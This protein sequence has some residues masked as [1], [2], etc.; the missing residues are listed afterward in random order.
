[1]IF[2]LHKKGIN[3]DMKAIKK[4]STA[5]LVGIAV[6]SALAFVVAFVCN[7]IPPIAGFLSLDVKDGVIAIATFIYGPLAG[8]A[9]AFIA[10]FIELITFSTT[11]WYGFIMNFASSAV[12]ALTAGLIYKHK[13]TLNGALIGF[14]AAVIA[15]T[16]IMLLLNIFVT[17]L[18]LT[19][20]VGLPREAADSQV[21]ELL[22]KVLLPF[23]FAKSLLNS[24]VAMLLYKPLAH[25][26]KRTGLALSTGGEKGISFNRSSILILIVGAVALAISVAIFLILA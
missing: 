13:R 18:Y 25:T 3:I 11:A 19:Y 23:N 14:F 2:K 7:I 8:V 26:V 20:F 16:G 22:P 9:I 5:R 10:A 12:F 17:P 1:M 24:S 21:M 6:F 4:N 15:T